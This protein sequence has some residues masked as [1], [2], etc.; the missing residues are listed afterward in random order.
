M[1]NADLYRQWKV[2]GILGA[3]LMLEEML[4]WNPELIE[5]G[6]SRGLYPMIISI[7]NR[8]SGWVPFS[9]FEWVLYAMAL[10]ILGGLALLG[11]RVITQGIRRTKGG[12]AAIR[13]VSVVLG[14]AVLF[15]GLWGLNYYRLSL[16]DQLGIASKG[17]SEG[18]L[19]ALCQELIQDANELGAAV[20]RDSQG[21]MVAQGPLREVLART[22]LGFTAARGVI[23]FI[24]GSFAPPK[25]V[26]Y[27]T[28]MSY[29]GIAGVYSPFTGEANVNALL[30]AAMIPA[31]AMHEVGHVYG[32]ARE[33][34]ANFIAWLTCRYH[35]DADYRYSGALLGLI[36][37]MN[38]LYAADPEE[39]QQLK[40]EYSAGV[41]ADM[42][43]NRDFWKRY[44]GPAEEIHEKVND[45]YLKANGQED[46]VASYGR[47][48]DLLLAV[49]SG[50]L[51]IDN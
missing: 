31:T 49:N 4:K 42:K 8:L 21:A 2:P 48:V 36:Y 51:K 10:A 43:A 5:R 28:G 27:S 15:N 39:Y 20:S 16:G 47:M 14:F 1:K 50:A 7:L 32:Y 18:E 37:G 46:G 17:Y 22:Q 11:H 13:M 24:E 35:P 6:Y 3:L 38:A 25:G 45:R 41:K 34:E 30:P 33:D 19:K 9:F 26:S 23:P 40:E 29:A 44:E 12:G